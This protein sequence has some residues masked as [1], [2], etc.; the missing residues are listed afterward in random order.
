MGAQPYVSTPY[1]SHALVQWLVDHVGTWP[2]W[3]NM[4]KGIIVIVIIMISIYIRTHILLCVLFLASIAKTTTI[5]YIYRLSEEGSK[6]MEAKECG[7]EGVRRSKSG[8]CRRSSESL[9]L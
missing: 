3:I 7:Q 2:F 1:P 6:D 8:V 5:F 4:T 9:F